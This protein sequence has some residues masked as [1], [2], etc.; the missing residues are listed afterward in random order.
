MRK[1]GTGRGSHR[2]RRSRSAFA[3]APGGVIETM[4]QIGVARAVT[5]RRRTLGWID[6]FTATAS[7]DEFFL[8]HGR[9]DAARA[10]ERGARR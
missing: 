7:A 10:A 9:G 6:G 5:A 3:V 8:D 1:G 2:I 4:A